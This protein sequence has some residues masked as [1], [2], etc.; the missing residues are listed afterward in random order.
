MFFFLIGCVRVC[1]YIFNKQETQTFDCAKKTYQSLAT[2]LRK[3]KSSCNRTIGLFNCTRLIDRTQ[4]W[5]FELSCTSPKALA[6]TVSK[7]ASL[8]PSRSHVHTHFYFS[9]QTAVAHN[10]FP[11]NINPVEIASTFS[12]VFTAWVFAWLLKVV[13]CCAFH[14]TARRRVR[15]Y[16][17][18]GLRSLAGGVRGISALCDITKSWFPRLHILFHAFFLMDQQTKR[19]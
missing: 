8:S 9:S 6:N 10:P 4:T 5:H 15:H 19:K 12:P 16:S 2:H 13:L 11:K 7:L 1:F 14:E 3:K 17:P 18:G